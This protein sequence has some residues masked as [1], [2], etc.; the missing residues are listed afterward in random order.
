[1]SPP[2]DF[3]IHASLAYASGYMGMMLSPV[4]ICFLVS[5]DY[6]KASLLASY[7]HLYKP[8]AAVT[9]TWA[10]VLALLSAL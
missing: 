2:P 9:G 5:K 6:F 3:F 7:R 10:A 4:H 8:V 1:V